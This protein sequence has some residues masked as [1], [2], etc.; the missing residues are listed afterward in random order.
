M[1]QATPTKHISINLALCTPMVSTKPLIL[2][3]PTMTGKL[4]FTM[5]SLLVWL[6]YALYTHGSN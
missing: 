1:F 3:K 2:E 5:A 4:N 6:L